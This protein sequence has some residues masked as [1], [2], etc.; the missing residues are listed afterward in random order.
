MSIINFQQSFGFPFET[1]TLHEMQEAYTIF[2]ALGELA[3]NKTIIQGC[4]T[5]NQNVSDGVIY[6]DGELLEFRGGIQQANVAIREEVTKVEFEDGE[7]KDTYFKRYAEFGTAIDAIPW[8][9]F[10]RIDNLLTTDADIELLNTQLT[11]LQDHVADLQEELS[12]VHGRTDLLEEDLEESQEKIEDL[13]NELNT[14]KNRILDLENQ[15]IHKEVKWVG[16]SVTNSSLPDNWFI[17]NGTNGTDD[18]LGKMIVGYDPTQTEFNAILKTGGEKSVTL[19]VN[20][21][22]SHNHGGYTNYAGNHTHNVRDGQG[23]SNTGTVLGNGGSS[24]NFSGQDSA[25]L[26]VSG[27][28]LISTT[29]N[30]R[31]T[32]YSQGGNQ[33]H[34][35]LP[36][37]ITMIPIQYIKP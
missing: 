1:N 7:Q 27:S 33:A 37:Y 8:S 4:E 30:H 24:P 34:N 10:K 13:E 19:T 3:G 32:V 28:N 16:R 35:N 15:T 25:R 36:P 18:I 26:W 23:G 29:G 22:P 9:D 11:N 31:H 20:Q 17:A 6:V 14:S 21:M 2:N 12:Y 5:S